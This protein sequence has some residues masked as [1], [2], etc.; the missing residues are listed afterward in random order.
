MMWQ[1]LW[2]YTVNVTTACTLDTLICFLNLNISHAKL[3]LT[4]SKKEFLNLTL[5]VISR[6]WPK[7]NIKNNPNLLMSVILSILKHPE[8]TNQYNT[9]TTSCTT[10]NITETL[11]CHMLLHTSFTLSEK[12]NHTRL[13]VDNRRDA[14]KLTSRER[15]QWEGGLNM[16]RR[17]KLFLSHSHVRVMDITYF[18]INGKTAS[19]AIH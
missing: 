13:I 2:I 17:Q 11:L 15:K 16:G 19:I 8:L 3:I 14:C 4:N 12:I 1:M 7:M 9:K 18:G 6:I 10:P 5:F